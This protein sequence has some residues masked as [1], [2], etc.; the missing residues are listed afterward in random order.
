MNWKRKLSSRKFWAAIAAA[1]ASFGAAIGVADSIVTQVVGII[2][3]VGSICY[4]IFTEGK[5]DEVNA[6]SNATDPAET[7][8]EEE[9]T[10][11]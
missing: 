8:V 11:E 5:I 10:N 6:I 2:G 1:I 4:Y 3:G 7:P 9:P